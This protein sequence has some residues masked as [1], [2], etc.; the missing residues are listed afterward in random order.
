MTIPLYLPPG[1]RVCPRRKGGKGPPSFF[2][3]MGQ[4]PPLL[5]RAAKDRALARLWVYFCNFFKKIKE[6]EVDELLQNKKY[7]L[8]TQ[9]VWDEVCSWF[10]CKVS[11]HLHSPEGQQSR[12]WEEECNKT[13]FWFFWGQRKSGGCHASR[14]TWVCLTGTEI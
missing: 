10:A 13:H 4:S 9:V 8:N 12:S 7:S 14:H 5:Y 6:A 3:P 11:L 2:S 1:N